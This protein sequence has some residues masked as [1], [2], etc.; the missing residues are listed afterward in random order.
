[1][2][3]TVN[4][5]DVLDNVN[6]VVDLTSVLSVRKAS[7]V[8]YLETANRVLTY[9]STDT[10]ID[11][12]YAYVLEKWTNLLQSNN[13][14][15]KQ[16]ADLQRSINLQK[17]SMDELVSR[18]SGIVDTLEDALTNN[19][20]DTQHRLEYILTNI[21]AQVTVKVKE[22]VEPSILQ[23]TDETETLRREIQRLS[24]LLKEPIDL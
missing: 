1:M 13:D 17:V 21:E 7:G 2:S 15:S 8:L 11:E 20:T 24:D 14:I 4:L 9:N 3:V 12:A 5:S 18:I 19:L 16:R 22:R 10:R 23:V 6:I